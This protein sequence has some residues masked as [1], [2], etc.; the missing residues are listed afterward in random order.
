MAN[1]NK[2]APGSQGSGKPDGGGNQGQ[3][4][5]PFSDGKNLSRYSGD[6][7]HERPDYEEERPGYDVDIETEIPDG[8]SKSGT[9]SSAGNRPEMDPSKPR[10]TREIPSP[11]D[12][13]QA[14][15]RP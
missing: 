6:Q 9:G 3:A 15:K 14:R 12:E 11:D 13:R 2:Q 5:D 4:Q 1:E 10:T 8:A 7:P